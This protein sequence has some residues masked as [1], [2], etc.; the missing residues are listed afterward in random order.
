MET[1]FRNW[2]VTRQL[3]S[4]IHFNG[5]I[6]DV[7]TYEW[8]SGRFP[9][10]SD[11]TLDDRVRM[12]VADDMFITWYLQGYIARFLNKNS[13]SIV[14][15]SIRECISKDWIEQHGD[16]FNVGLKENGIIHY[17]FYPIVAFFN[18]IDKNKSISATFWSLCALL[19]I[20]ILYPLF[21]HILIFLHVTRN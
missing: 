12:G 1:F 6:L 17:W 18:V 13:R 11:S 16:R 9:D 4:Y 10:F 15:R 7:I 3:Y 20:W 21:L 14:R 8:G 19:W 5:K 2:W